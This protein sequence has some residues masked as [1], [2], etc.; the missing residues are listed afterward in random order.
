MKKIFTIGFAALLMVSCNMDFYPS[1]AMTSSQL[2]DNPSSAIYTTD[3]IYSLFK[4][5]LAYKGES[6]DYPN[7]R[8]QYLRHYYQLTELRSDNVTVSG[9]TSDPFVHP[10]DYQD[11]PTEENIYYTWWLAYKVIYGANSN[12]DAITPGA[13]AES[14]HLLGENYFLRALGHFHLVTLFSMPYVYWKDHQDALGIP[15][16]RGMDSYSGEVKRPSVG[17]VYDEIV[18]DL[19]E[20]QKYLGAEGVRTDR[21]YASLD[22]AK[23]LLARVYLYMEKN[24]ECLDLCNE[25]LGGDPAAN[26]EPTSGLADY[27][28]RTRTSKETLWCIACTP[29]DAVGRSSLGSMYFSPNGTGGVGQELQFIEVFLCLRLVLV[30]RNQTHQYGGLGLYLGYDKFFH[31]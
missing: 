16:H 17:Q 9:T 7:G 22:A 28:T 1:D 3:G 4:D 12:I 19:I 21:G 31:N 10:Y 6:V 30:F 25:M 15:I 24:Q 14:D 29:Q 11:V 5:Y 8:N 18:L 26:L 2:A 20:A 27:F 23:A 13:S